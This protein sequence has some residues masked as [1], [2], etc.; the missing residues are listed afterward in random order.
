MGANDGPAVPGFE[1]RRK[2]D[3]TRYVQPYL[4]RSKVTGRA[5]RPYKSFPASMTEAE[6]E[7]AAA[8]WLA[9]V[10]AA[11]QL[12]TSCRLGELLDVYVDGLEDSGVAAN[13]VK[14]YRIW[15]NTY[16]RPVRGLP[17][18][19]VTPWRLESLYADLQRAGGRGGAPLSASTVRSFAWFLSGAFQWLVSVGVLEDNPC[20]NARVP[21]PEP[22]EA[23]A[24]EAPSMAVLV[25]AL[26]GEA[27]A[28]VGT[29]GDATRRCSAFLA[30]LALNTGVRVGES[31]ALR[32]SDFKTRGMLHVAGTVTEAGGVRRQPTTKGKQSRNVALT[33]SVVAD[34]SRH[35][36]WEDQWL[37]SPVSSGSAL[38]LATPN[39]EWMRPTTVGR[40][41][42]AICDDYGLPREATFHTL[43]HTHATWLLTEGVDVKTV[44]E[45]LGHR[46]PSMTQRIYGHVLPGRDQGAA[47]LF[48]DVARRFGPGDA[49]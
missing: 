35:L 41:F 31:C 19:D 45:R 49:R 11:T 16:A 8:R 13:T 24:L 34:V 42:R 38:P 6:V 36:A 47:D 33:R 39:G 28:E 14:S 25:N 30:W 48:G 3:G 7:D 10:G 1:V 15:A 4:G 32:R 23:S 12:G 18:Y 21:R 26:V 2:P 5:I 17:P 37:G 22:Y 20:Q 44:S 46:D 9:R 43:R 29:H 27:F 40:A